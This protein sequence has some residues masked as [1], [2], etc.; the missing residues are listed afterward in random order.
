[1]GAG[2]WASRVLLVPV[3]FAAACSSEA[4]TEP[5]AAPTPSIEMRP[6]AGYVEVPA[7]TRGASDRARMFYSFHPADAHPER[8]PLLVFFNGGP[9]AATSGVLLPFGTGP[10]T[11]LA[12]D[13]GKGPV[14]NRASYTHFANLL[15]LDERDAGFSYELGGYEPGAGCAGTAN[16]VTDAG[17][18]VFALL[19]FLDAHARLARSHVVL[20]GESYGGTRA[21]VMLALLQ[22][23]AH[24]EGVKEEVPWLPARMQAHLDLAFPERAGEAWTP[25]QVAAQLGW[26]VLIEPVFMGAPQTELQLRA[27]ATDPMVASAIAEQRSPFDMRVS[28]HAHQALADRVAHV[29]REPGALEAILGVPLESIVGLA[30][31]ERGKVVREVRDGALGAIAADEHALRARLGQIGPS[32]AYF[33]RHVV[34]RCGGYL[35]DENSARMLLDGLSRT[36]AFIT[37][38]RY[39][40][41]VYARAIPA[42]LATLQEGVTVDA[43]A[44]SGVARPGLIRIAPPG[45]APVTIRFPPY[46]AGHSVTMSAAAELREDVEAWL[47]ETDALPR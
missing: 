2:A 32:D 1:M 47:R 17:D 5:P 44:P 25:E 4:A 30:A 24:L 13:L 21:P 16:Y 19:S 14:D 31:A 11:L 9:G 41:A 26:E 29:M 15:Y 22:R 33:L 42:I 46:E 36:H 38:A 39:D 27:E 43:A 37:D 40:S 45:K 20:V 23:Y 7:Q 28:D 8:A 35:G 34:P 6:E 18:F 10:K 3:A 12:D